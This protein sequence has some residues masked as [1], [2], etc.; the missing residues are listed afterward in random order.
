MALNLYR[1]HGS[2]CAGRR[3]LH[4]M[5]YE[6]DELRR[7]WKKCSCPIYVSGTLN[8]RFKRKNTE[9]ANWPE[10]KSV[11]AAWEA[12]GKWEGDTSVL[13]RQSP[14]ESGESRTITSEVATIERAVTAFL[15]EHSESSA[16]NTQK[17]YGIIMKKL[18]AYSAEKGYVMIGQWG[19]VDVREFRQSWQVSPVTSAKSM[20]TVKAFFEFVLSNEWITRNPVRL[21]KNPRGRVGDNPRTK[22]RIP[23]TDEELKRMFEA[24]ETQYGKRPIRWSRKVHHRPAEPG[25]TVNYRYQWDGQ[26]LA[27]FISVS[28]YTGL[29]ISDVCTFRIDRLRATGECHIRTTKNGRNV[30]TWI[31]EWLQ[32]RI[33][34]RANEHGLIF[35]EHSTT[36]INVITDVWRRKLKR[37]WNLCGPWPE[38]PTPHR[39]RH[40][41]ARI[42]L[43]RPSVT[44]RD[45][46]ELIGDTE[47]MVR[48]HYGAWV[49]ERQERL[50]S[51]LKEAFS[52]KPKPKLVAVSGK[53]R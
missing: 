27:D 25:E 30:Y 19:P 38:K 42:L 33:R 48:R 37:L 14:L 28:V 45:V 9:Q 11:A 44:V 17:K 39:F 23:F 22:E 34:A 51:V 20:S 26:D 18:K 47:E 13:V 50:T 41:F 8:G 21:V 36:D 2:K 52:E 35:G 24:C 15:A 12:V 49:T 5:T 29:R 40:T 32:E 7:A 16:P 43:Q 4:E 3:I 10:A 6:A 53:R 1:R 46:A 31:P